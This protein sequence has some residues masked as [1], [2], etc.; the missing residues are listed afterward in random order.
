LVEEFIKSQLRLA[1]AN[2]DIYRYLV[3]EEK[4][5]NSFL[6]LFSFALVYAILQNKKDEKK[7]RTTFIPISQISSQQVR[8]VLLVCY[9]I[10]NDGRPMKDI[11]EDL[12]AYADEGVIAVNEIYKKNKSFILSNLI[13][14]SEKLWQERVKDLK[15][16]RLEKST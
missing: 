12:M 1:S 4:L 6:H 5:F 10:L 11:Y 2:L 7:I 3:D 8:D 9:M 15:N 14:D 16:I 13:N